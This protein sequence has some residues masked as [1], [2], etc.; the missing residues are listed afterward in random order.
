MGLS[1][2][3]PNFGLHMALTR[4]VVGRWSPY[5]RVCSPVQVNKTLKYGS[6]R[7]TGN[8]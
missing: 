3:N 7:P 4:D 2:I 8:K 5:C 6:D 1:Y